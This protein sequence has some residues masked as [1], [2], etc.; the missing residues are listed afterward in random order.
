[1]KIRVVL[2]KK[3]QHTTP[4]NKQ[5]HVITIRPGSGDNIS[6]VVNQVYSSAN[7]VISFYFLQD[8][9]FSTIIIFIYTD[10]YGVLWLIRVAS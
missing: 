7:T 8:I 1:M 9:I 2:F 3:S 5:T 6:N 10:L 4:S